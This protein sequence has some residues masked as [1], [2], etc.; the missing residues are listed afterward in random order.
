MSQLALNQYL[1]MVF[2]TL[3]GCDALT[4]LYQFLSYAIDDKMERNT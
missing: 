2:L 1:P 4:L 3:L